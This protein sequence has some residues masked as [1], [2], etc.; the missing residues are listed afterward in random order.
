[1]R[2]KA[3]LALSFCAGALLV[4]DGCAKLENTPPEAVAPGIAVHPPGWSDPASANFHGKAIAASSWD[5]RQCRTCHGQTYAGGAVGVSCLTCH[6]KS[7]GP[8]NCTTCHGSTNPAPPKDV[9]GNTST[10]AL[11]VGAHQVHLVGPRTISNTPIN[12]SDCH[13]VPGSV[14]EPGHVD[15]PLPAEVVINNPL[16]KTPTGGITPAPAFDY[17]TGRCSNTYC[18]G[19]WRLKRQGTSLA[20]AYNDTA[21]AMYGNNISPLWNGGDP[22]AACGTCHGS[23]TSQGPS[24]VPKGH[25]FSTVTGCGATFCHAGIVDATGKISDPVKH[26]NGKVNVQGQEYSFR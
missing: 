14:Y 15:S 16:S 6:T 3:L 10:T 25:N 21:T 2:T 24:P 20:F 26:M 11:G 23:M 22:E 17:A 12:C 5:M 1:M 19:N 4:L 8:E 13:H 7:A 18:H 9:S